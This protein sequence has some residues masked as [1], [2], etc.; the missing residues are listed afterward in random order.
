MDRTI[1]LANRV[2]DGL[3]RCQPTADWTDSPIARPRELLYGVYLRS[4]LGFLDF[5]IILQSGGLKETRAGWF[6]TKVVV[7]V[8]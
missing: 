4:V 8:Y 1:L 3:P 7:V 2:Q 6:S 5:H